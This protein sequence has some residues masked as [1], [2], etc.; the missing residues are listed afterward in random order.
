MRNLQKRPATEVLRVASVSK[1]F[2][3][4]QILNGI[5]LALPQHQI[6]ALCGPSGSGKS[7]LLRIISGLI[8]FDAGE[9]T[10]DGR[11]IRAEAPYPSELFGR[12][13]L[14]FQEHNLFPHLTAISNVTLALR[15]F[16]RRPPREAHERGMAELDRMGVAAL[17]GEYP[18]TLS[19]GE[20][21]RVAI[22][23]AL[24]LD[25]FL[26]LLDEPTAQLDPDRMWDVRD[27]VLQLA[28]AGM[29][30]ML[31]THNVALARQAATLFALMQ[32]GAMHVSDSC[33]ILKLLEP[34]RA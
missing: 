18:A 14:I 7:T 6:M 24:A 4:R 30:M 5:T 26:L 29:T 3:T 22:A 15:E 2:G 27:R 32:D 33:S 19:G 31:V 34:Q 1:R 20:R 8:P 12:I 13:G 11:T 23:R 25:P 10:I 28:N 17:A 9:L 16:K 21:Q